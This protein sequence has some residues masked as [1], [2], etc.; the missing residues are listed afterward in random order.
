MSL[1]TTPGEIWTYIEKW[2]F[3]VLSYVT[4]KGE[5]RAAGVM[6]TVSSRVLYVATGSDTWKARHIRSNPNVSVTVTVQRLPVTVRPVPPAVITFP[7]KAKV[8]SFDEV[9][10]DVRAKLTK[11]LDVPMGD[12]SVIQIMPVGRFVT[13]GIGVPVMKMRSPTE[14]LARVPMG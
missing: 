2:P 1:P 14:S 12:H 3:A 8:V 6:Y 10:A 4:P 13:Y 9:N 5:A 11:G 7:G